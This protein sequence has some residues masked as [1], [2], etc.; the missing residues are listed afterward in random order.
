MK[1]LIPSIGL[2]L[3]GI[4]F[5]LPISMAQEIQAQNSASSNVQGSG[6]SVIGLR[7]RQLGESFND[8]AF[9]VKSSLTFNQESKIEALKERNKE[10]KERQNNWVQTK[11]EATA[12]FKSNLTAEQK[13]KILA[14]LKLEHQAII[15]NHIETTNQLRQIQLNAKAKGNAQLE[16][17]AREAAEESEDETGIG[18]FIGIN[19]GTGLKIGNQEHDFDYDAQLQTNLTGE[20]ARLIVQDE[21][22]FETSNVKTVVNDNTRFYVVTGHEAQTKGEYTMTRN[23][24][25]WVH[26][27][28]GIITSVYI[29]TKVESHAKITASSKGSQKSSNQTSSLS[30]SN[31]GLSVGIL[32]HLLL[33]VL[34]V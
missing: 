2:L 31:S 15:R 33:L 5:L 3:I 24:E 12:D 29:G 8:F 10:L 32:L 17:K 30:K 1:K 26:A 16:E 34:Q 18:L 14:V 27:D 9:K 20:Q 13:Q 23:F 6:T 21:L 4:V 11:Q 25:V 19:S 7:F 28:S 22:G